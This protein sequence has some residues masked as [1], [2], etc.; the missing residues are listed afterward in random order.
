MLR[1]RLLGIISLALVNASI[2]SVAR[3]ETNEDLDAAKALFEEGR[4]LMGEGKYD[5]ACGKFEESQAKARG[6][7]TKF[8]LADCE[9]H[10]GNFGKAQTLFIE[11]AEQAR[12][13]GQ[14]DR[15]K[16]ARGR[17]TA[18]DEKLAHLEIDQDPPGAD[19]QVDDR[20]LTASEAQGMLTIP[21]GKHRIVASAEGKKTWTKDIDV[22]KP[23]MFVIVT[24]PPLEDTAKPPVVAA[25]AVIAPAKQTPDA[26]SDPNAGRGQRRAALV[27]GGVG[28]GA[29][30]AGIAFGLQFL[31]NNHDAK[32]V[33]PT[34][35]GCTEA[36]IEQHAAYI[37]D[38]H[39]ARTRAYVSFGVGAA[40]LAGAA[41]L[42]FTA[43]K[44]GAVHATAGLGPN[45][46][47]N[48][49]IR[50]GF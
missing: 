12:E 8:N 47:W 32:N 34:S 3:A 45:G 21:P 36:E 5:A 4:H 38:A 31:A 14:S 30:V 33:C 43:P 44:P 9:E 50:G 41:V 42:Y 29:T 27:L 46:A 26:D 23:G 28:V 37:D 19:I 1:A 18:I 11:V 49:A 48:V 2:C 20:K 25:A 24:V 7:G 17:A 13:A 40:A 6:I 22:P 35:Y 10:R 15:E 39:A 16:L